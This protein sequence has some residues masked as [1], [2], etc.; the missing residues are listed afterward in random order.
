MT[1]EEAIERLKKRICNEGVIRADKTYH[2]CTDECM[3]GK[4]YCEIAL[5][6]EAL[7]K[8]IPKKPIED[9]Y[10]PSCNAIAGKTYHYCWCCGQA[11]DWSSDKC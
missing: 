1:N 3:H 9:Y 10:C 6:I 4:K 2:F 8:Q 7:E 11:L 5:A